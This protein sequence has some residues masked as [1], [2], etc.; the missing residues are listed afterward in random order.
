MPANAAGIRIEPPPSVPTCS[1]PRPAAAAGR[2]A[3]ARPARRALEVPRIARDA[4]EQVVRGADPAHGRRVRLAEHD[5]A[6]GLQAGHDR[7]VLGGHV[8]AIERRAERRA[9]ALGD[10]EIL[11]GERH[12]VQRPQRGAALGQRALGGPRFPPCLLGRQ[13]DKRVEAR[14]ELVDAIENRAEHLDRGYL[15]LA[16]EPGERRRRLPVQ[17]HERRSPRRPDGRSRRPSVRQPP[18][19]PGTPRA[20]VE[21]GLRPRGVLER[22]AGRSEP[23]GDDAPTL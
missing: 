20:E 7:R 18:T 12:A 14:I 6:G 9:H 23:A 10:D 5:A 16:D 2:G 11:H 13:R 8:V 3:A 19:G 21:R 22:E 4:E 15:L 17:V 1:G